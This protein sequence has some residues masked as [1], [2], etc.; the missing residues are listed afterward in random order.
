MQ[1]GQLHHEPSGVE[2]IHGI[3]PQSGLA[4]HEVLSATDGY[5]WFHFM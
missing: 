4:T 5:G 2:K 3:P 1:G